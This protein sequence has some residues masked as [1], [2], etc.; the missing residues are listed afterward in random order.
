MLNEICNVWNAQF[1]Q[2][3]V[4]YDDRFKALYFSM[5]PSPLPS[6]T[7][8]LLQDLRQFQIL[9]RQFLSEDARRGERQV[10]YLIFASDVPGIFQLGGDLK[11]FL[12]CIE[13]DDRQTLADY[14]HLSIDVLHDNFINLGQ[15]ISTIALVDGNALGAGF[16]SALSCDYIIAE[17]D[18]EFQFPETIFNMFPG[19]GAYSFLSRR[20]GP[21]IVEQM[22]KTGRPYTAA[23]LNELG[24]IDKLA[25]P[26]DARTALETFLVKHR[27]NHQTL[28]AITQMRNITNPISKE[29]LMKIA[30]LWV[31]ASMALPAMSRKIM[32]RI[33]RAQLKNVSREQEEM[34]SIAKRG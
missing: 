4:R 2:L 9:A 15:N 12:D 21:A 18:A 32:G 11:F 8:R 5:Q 16:E 22:I 33:V 7:P 34:P 30:D 28:S 17:K 3:E 23:E 27:R 24:L 26:G 20:V 31:D 1:E 10:E 25:E 6:F 29:E 19:M 13:A 14:A